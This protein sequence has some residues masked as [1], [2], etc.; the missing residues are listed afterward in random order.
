[1][2][3]INKINLQ[4]SVYF[5]LC[6][7]IAS[8]QVKQEAAE[9]QE[10]RNA[11]YIIP[12]DFKDMEV[13]RLGF[14]YLINYKNEIFKYDEYF[15][16]L[17]KTSYNTLGT[18]DYIDVSNPQKVLVYHSDFQNVLFLDNTLSQINTLNLESLGFWNIGTVAPSNDNL[19]WIYDPV[20]YKLI[21]INENGKEQLSSNE[22][23]SG[24]IQGRNSP[25]IISRDDKIYLFTEEQ[26]MIFN[27]FGDFD[28]AINLSN[29]GIQFF[30]SDI[31]Y[32]KENQLYSRSTKVEFITS[33]DQ[34]LY[35]YDHDIRDFYLNK[36]NTIY[37][38]DS[39]G[40]FLTSQK[41]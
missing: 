32:N 24:G 4:L 5:L 41:K 11:K 19:I 38:L 12:G 8:C 1:M 25:R 34:L 6:I 27:I 20:N 26:L 22:L 7:S 2:S 31:V 21:K 30:S 37:T 23:F 3:L 28:K 15:K 35:Q 9:Q 40:V 17:F 16:L 14:I 29:N 33:E 10:Q 39:S 18:I 36:D 13:D